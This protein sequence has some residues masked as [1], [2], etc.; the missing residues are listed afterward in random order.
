MTMLITLP[1]NLAP[2]NPSPRGGGA[3]AIG[4]IFRAS[5]AWCS[6]RPAESAVIAAARCIP[7]VCGV[8]V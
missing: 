6:S 4:M 8:L 1:P 7:G 5:A 2:Y 3:S